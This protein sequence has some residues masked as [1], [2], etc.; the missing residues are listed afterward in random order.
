MQG[1]AWPAKDKAGFQF[2]P[3]NAWPAKA[4]Q[5]NAGRGNAGQGASGARQG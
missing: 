1:M 5:G 4:G 3:G 2:F